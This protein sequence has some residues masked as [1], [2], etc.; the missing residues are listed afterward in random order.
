MVTVWKHSRQRGNGLL[1]ML[2]LAD[3][4]NDFGEAWP[5]I[6]SLATKTRCSRT[7]V[8]DMTKRCQLE[9]ELVI[10][11][12]DG[13]NGTNRYKLGVYYRTAGY[14]IPTATSTGGSPT[15]GVRN[16]PLGLDPILQEPSS[17]PESLEGQVPNELGPTS[18]V[19]SGPSRDQTPW[20]QVLSILKR[21]MP[22]D[23]FETWVQPTELLSLSGDV[24]TVAGANSV[25]ISKL[26]NGHRGEIEAAAGEVFRRK[27]RI[28][29]VVL[30]KVE[31]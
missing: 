29:F 22:R 26:E 9:G 17:P 23:E 12:G 28:R 7:T 21:G 13:R 18:G 16:A 2:A 31:A 4:M 8:I 10:G 11:E 25:G 19:R 14:G 6:D 27:V 20:V 3:Y 5:S 24:L 30:S 15:Q 1:L